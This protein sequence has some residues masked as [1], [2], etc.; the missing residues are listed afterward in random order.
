[1]ADLTKDLEFDEK[2]VVQ[3]ISEKKKIEE[4]AK[5]LSDYFNKY[6]ELRPVEIIFDETA[7][8]WVVKTKKGEK[9]I[10]HPEAIPKAIMDFRV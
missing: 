10:E 8:N 4:L 1:M 5:E 9:D 3:L 7:R 6:E 2:Y